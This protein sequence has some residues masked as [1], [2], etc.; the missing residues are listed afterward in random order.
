M[1]PAVP[2][3]EPRYRVLRRTSTRA[4]IDP[5]SPDFV[6]WVDF[7]PGRT[8]KTWPEHTP[9]SEWVKSGHWQAIDDGGTD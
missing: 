3:P 9:V 8:V 4:S 6:R 2:K 7:N 1:P 5:E